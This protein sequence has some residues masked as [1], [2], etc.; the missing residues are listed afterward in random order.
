MDLEKI[1]SDY[2]LVSLLVSIV[3]LIISIIAL[4]YTVLTYLLKS[5]VRFRC[6]LSVT[7]SV[8]TED[9]Y[10]SSITLENLKDKPAVIFEIFLRIGNNNYLLLEEFEKSPLILA[11]FEVYYR[12]YDPVVFYLDSDE[13]VRFKDFAFFE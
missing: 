10:I 3:A 7:S 1:I 13:R 11:P 6:D 9:K 2:N 12:K 8:E 5:G 4:V